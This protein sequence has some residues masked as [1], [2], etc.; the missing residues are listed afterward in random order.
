V[1]LSKPRSQQDPRSTTRGLR[2]RWDL[3]HRTKDQSS[4]VWT[5]PFRDGRH[6]D[7]GKWQSVDLPAQTNLL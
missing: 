4:A 3:N 6:L 1:M 2:V 5:D 7:T